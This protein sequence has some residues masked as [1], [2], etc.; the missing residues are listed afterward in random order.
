MRN[1]TLKNLWNE[2]LVL[3][4]IVLLRL[5]EFAWLV[6]SMYKLVLNFRLTNRL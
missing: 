3:Y 5:K 4:I 2:Y 1:R 6:Y